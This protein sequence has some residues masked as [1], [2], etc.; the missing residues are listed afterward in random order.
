MREGKSTKVVITLESVEMSDGQ[1]LRRTITI[2]GESLPEWPEDTGPSGLRPLA[3]VAAQMMVNAWEDRV[4][5]GERE[6][7]CPALP[8][9]PH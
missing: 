8:G 5:K 3:I 1:Q 9:R 2:N 4:R 7:G 6:T